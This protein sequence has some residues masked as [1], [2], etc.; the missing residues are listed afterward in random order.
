MMGWTSWALT[1][2]VEGPVLQHVH[3]LRSGLCVTEVLSSLV[4]R[5]EEKSDCKTVESSLGNRRS[6][7]NGSRSPINPEASSTCEG[8]RVLS[9]RVVDSGH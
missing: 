3:R 4:D 2:G 6:V 8:G 5:R 7:E 1:N 9:L